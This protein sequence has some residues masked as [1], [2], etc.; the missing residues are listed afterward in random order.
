MP[1]PAVF[2]HQRLP[3]RVLHSAGFSTTP[4][5][6]THGPSSAPVMDHMRI[7]GVAHRSE[8]RELGFT[9]KE[10]RL[11]LEAGIITRVGAF[12]VTSRAPAALLTF[13]EAGVRPTCFTAAVLHELWVPLHEHAHVFRP[14]GVDLEMLDEDWIE[15]GRGLRSWPDV[16]PIADLPLTLEHAARCA[17]ARDAAILFESAV[18]QRKISLERAR[19]I[20]E[21]LPQRV[22]DPL[23]RIDP[24]AESG[25][26]TAV[27][28][29][30]ESR[31]VPATPQ[32]HIA[33][34]GR[35]DL[36]VGRSWIIECDSTKHHDNPA[37]YHEDRG[38]DLRLRAKGFTVTRLTWEQVFLDWKETEQ[39]L[40]QCIRRRDH[41][42]P[43][44][45]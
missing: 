18:Q 25:T 41:Q 6:G 8:L 42:Q 44:P 1:P 20:V 31:R 12:Y 23:R 21:G 16:S 22:R 5:A 37:Q 10:R 19:R 13:L 15:H 36:K 4:A 17:S 43:L 9:D 24:R 29:W 26:E 27:R 14:R 28:W 33:G 11:Q 40:L 7:R 3:R 39:E 45:R 30:F 38:R 32:V 34:V 2:R 35:V